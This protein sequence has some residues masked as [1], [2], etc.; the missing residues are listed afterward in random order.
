MIFAGSEQ[1]WE[2]R[3]SFRV[4]LVL[5]CSSNVPEFISQTF[6]G[7]RDQDSLQTYSIDPPIYGRYVRLNPR[8]WRSHIAMRLELYGGPWGKSFLAIHFHH[9]VL[10]L[11]GWSLRYCWGQCIL[12]E[13]SRK[14]THNLQQTLKPLGL[15]G[16]RGLLIWS[17]FS[18]LARPLGL[19]SKEN[20]VFRRWGGQ[21]WE[22]GIQGACK[23][24]ISIA[25]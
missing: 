24:Q 20:V 25:S 19:V 9:R 10:V 15:D 16:I 18:G 5:G 6:T 11:L 14:D 2:R 13:F 22:F 17:R 23:G 7:N 1:P 4:L 12:I 8:G 21:T 3:I